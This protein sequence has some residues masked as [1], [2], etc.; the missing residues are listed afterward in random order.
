MPRP[1]AVS[2]SMN[3]EVTVTG[4]VLGRRLAGAEA[5]RVG[6]ASRSLEHV[7][8]P[9]AALQGLDVPG[10]GHEVAPEAVDGEL[11]DDPLDVTDGQ[12]RLEVGQPGVDALL[13]RHCG[14]VWASMS[15]SHVSQ[16]TPGR[17]R[18]QEL[19]SR[20]H[21]GPA[22]ATPCNSFGVWPPVT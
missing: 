2:N 11:A 5:G 22:D 4:A 1:T 13:R 14:V 8:D 21:T 10:E 20:L 7:G 16:D 9:V 19:R 3:A 18:W 12:R 6:P 15:G 17:R